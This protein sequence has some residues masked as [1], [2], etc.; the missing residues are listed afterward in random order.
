[1]STTR[2]TAWDE[3]DIP[4]VPAADLATALSLWL[5]REREGIAL[6]TDTTVVS[7]QALEA[8]IIA[9]HDHPAQGLSV[10]LRTRCLAATLSTARLRHLMRSEHRASLA[11]V[12][13]AAASIRLNPRWGMS[14]TRLVWAMHTASSATAAMRAAA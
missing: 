6:V 14:P 12:V 9:M 13:E 5:A 7:P 10:L 3:T 11:A 4:A 2:F 8:R 1:M